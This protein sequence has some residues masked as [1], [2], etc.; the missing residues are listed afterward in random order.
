MLSTH[1][2]DHIVSDVDLYNDQYPIFKD[3]LEVLEKKIGTMIKYDHRKI[4][5]VTQF[6]RGVLFYG[7]DFKPNGVSNFEPVL[8][9][10]RT[11][12]DTYHFTDLMGIYSIDTSGWSASYTGDN[13]YSHRAFIAHEIASIEDLTP[14]EHTPAGE[15]T[16]MFNKPFRDMT[17]KQIDM[18]INLS[19]KTF[20]KSLVLRTSH[21]L[22]FNASSLAMIQ[23]RYRGE[24]VTSKI[25]ISDK[26]TPIGSVMLLSE[27]L[28]LDGSM[29]A[30]CDKCPNKL[31]CLIN[32]STGN[33][34]CRYLMHQAVFN[35]FFKDKTLYNRKALMAFPADDGLYVTEYAL[36]LYKEFL[37]HYAEIGIKTFMEHLSNGTLY[38]PRRMGR[39][40]IINSMDNIVRSN[41]RMWCSILNVPVPEDTKEFSLGLRASEA[42]RA[43]DLRAE[44]AMPILVNSEAARSL[45]K[46]YLSPI[47]ATHNKNIELCQ[48]V[49][50]PNTTIESLIK[51]DSPFWQMLETSRADNYR[52]SITPSVTRASMLEVYHDTKSNL[53]AYV[54]NKAASRS[55]VYIG[56]KPGMFNSMKNHGAKLF[57]LAAVGAATEVA[58]EI[59]QAIVIGENSCKNCLMRD[60]VGR[61]CISYERYGGK[62]NSLNRHLMSKTEE[63]WGYYRNRLEEININKL[64][65]REPIYSMEHLYTWSMNR[66][67]EVMSKIRSSE[68]II[69]SIATACCSTIEWSDLTQ[70]LLGERTINGTIFLTEDVVMPMKFKET[71]ENRSMQNKKKA[72]EAIEKFTKH[73][74]LSMFLK[75]S[76]VTP[77]INPAVYTEDQGYLVLY[78]P[79]ICLE[80]N[81]YISSRG[82]YCS[83]TGNEYINL[84]AMFNAA[85]SIYAPDPIMKMMIEEDL[86]LHLYLEISKRRQV[87]GLT[88]TKQYTAAVLGKT[89]TKEIRRDINLEV[90]V[91]RTEEYWY[92]GRYGRYC[93]DQ[94]SAD[95][96]QLFHKKNVA[97]FTEDCEG[98]SIEFIKYEDQNKYELVKRK[99]VSYRENRVASIE[100]RRSM[101]GYYV[102][103]RLAGDIIATAAKNLKELRLIIRTALFAIHSHKYM[104][105]WELHNSMRNTFQCR[106]VGHLALIFDQHIMCHNPNNCLTS[107][108]LRNITND[109]LR[110]HLGKIGKTQ[111]LLECSQPH[112]K[113]VFSV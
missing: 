25:N 10:L 22:M 32:E 94:S 40:G 47:R 82:G 5:A 76:Y 34:Q 110:R 108:N 57:K 14:A 102:E 66:Y 56:L 33:D 39:M 31:L 26:L 70:I 71:K 106:K 61:N 83:E 6:Y 80:K 46:K 52:I 104:L 64:L 77:A 20:L 89:K 86:R 51:T 68:A 92:T 69:R 84:F 111:L 48:L 99:N 100:I 30:L 12:V 54:K 96:Q 60:T 49:F 27:A 50:F 8:E 90:I 81:R 91:D 11:Y 29:R 17:D 59:N 13:G 19:T 85:E 75:W 53:K 109:F 45:P 78:S 28:G 95:R 15:P 24:D 87:E 43:K 65:C 67:N 23:Y 36:N 7:M 35:T 2:F 18:L 37:N 98:Y 97:L 73:N 63:G 38:V 103:I 3:K 74:E 107:P 21:D 4:M 101:Y 62:I 58:K 41:P 79:N 55:F 1:D 112:L 42:A 16:G 44:R 105:L 93:Q 113:E 72:I 9:E 88:S